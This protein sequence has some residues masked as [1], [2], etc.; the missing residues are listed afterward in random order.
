VTIRA[1]AD[2][3]QAAQP[4]VVQTNVEVDSV[5][6]QI[7]VVDMAQVALLKRRQ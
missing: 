6:P 4:L 2:H 7:D 1:H 5:G 3:H